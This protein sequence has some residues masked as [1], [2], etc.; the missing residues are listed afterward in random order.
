MKKQSRINGKR[1]DK[2]ISF[3]TVGY[4]LQ[5]RMQVG[6]V[7][8]LKNNAVKTRIQENVFYNLRIEHVSQMKLL[9][10]EATKDF[11]ISII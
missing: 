2:S 9:N 1:I 10:P 4:H 6:K 8:I 7:L 3:M 11:L 5:K